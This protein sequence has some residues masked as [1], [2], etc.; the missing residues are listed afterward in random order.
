MPDLSII[1]TDLQANGMAVSG[2]FG[3][4]TTPVILDMPDLD[5]FGGFSQTRE[6]SIRLQASA[7]PALKHGD[8]VMV[9]GSAYTVREVK[10]LSD[11]AELLALLSKN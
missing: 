5:Q 3:A 6:Y 11:G 2:T 1:Y 9:D 8:A 4:V 10:R 7:W